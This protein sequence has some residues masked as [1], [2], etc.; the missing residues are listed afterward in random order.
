LTSRSTGSRHGERPDRPPVRP[1]LHPNSRTDYTERRHDQPNQIVVHVS[2]AFTD[3][4][5]ADIAYLAVFNDSNIPDFEYNRNIIQ[6][7]VWFEF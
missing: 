2:H 7:S 3:M 1:G 4:I 6:A 5:S